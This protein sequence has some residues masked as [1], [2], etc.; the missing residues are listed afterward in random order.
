MVVGIESNVVDMEKG[1]WDKNG[2]YV[3]FLNYLWRWLLKMKCIRVLM[4]DVMVVWICVVI[5]FF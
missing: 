2:Y 3:L 5:E 1:D 4:Y